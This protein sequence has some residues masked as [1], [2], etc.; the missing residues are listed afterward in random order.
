ME[1]G[2]GDVTGLLQAMRAGDRDAAEALLP[3]VYA[4]LH[5][6]ARSYMRR[7]RPE[8][9]LQTTA[10]IHEAYLRL[11]H[12][13][14]DWKSR[15]HFVG[16]AANVMRSVLVDYARAHKAEVRGGG[17]KRVEFHEDLAL[18]ADKL[19][20]VLVLDEALRKLAGNSPRQARVVE[21]RWFG[22][23]SVEEIAGLLGVAPRSVKRDWALARITLF[24]A[25]R[26]G[27]ADPV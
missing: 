24:R 1:S 13:E 16:L 6:L 4:E 18:S 27:Q 10:L 20:E 5:R 3:L 7:E 14:I 23:L 8:H 2:S 9:T 17:L 21:L 25:L 15:E 11:A 12:E 26:P 19:D 22:G